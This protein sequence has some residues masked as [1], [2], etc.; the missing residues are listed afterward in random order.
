MSNK[1]KKTNETKTKSN[2][3]RRVLTQPTRLS[4][5]RISYETPRYL[6]AVSMT[7]NIK[8]LL[9]INEEIELF[10]RNEKTKGNKK[11]KKGGLEIYY[12]V[13]PFFK[14]DP[15]QQNI[16]RIKFDEHIVIVLYDPKKKVMECFDSG[17]YYWIPG[18]CKKGK[19]VSTQI[20]ETA[21]REIIQNDFR[22]EMV[23]YHN[24]QT[25]KEDVYCQTYIYYY[26]LYRVVANQKP[27]DI[28]MELRQMKPKDRCTLMIQFAELLLSS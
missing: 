7:D 11:I 5:R 26:L 22:F 15:E 3:R 19:M 9:A 6:M 1:R 27:K 10:K 2:K 23:N 13:N 17:G 24:L 4:L 16:I 14:F 21:L 12:E 25:L 20:I 8:N 28:L 18:F